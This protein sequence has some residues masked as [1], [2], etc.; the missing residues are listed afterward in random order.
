MPGRLNLV[1]VATEATTPASSLGPHL[2]LS[3]RAGVASKGPHF[4]TMI[5]RRGGPVA[6]GSGSRQGI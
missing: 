1:S 3:E 4:Q 2:L 6:L 5:L